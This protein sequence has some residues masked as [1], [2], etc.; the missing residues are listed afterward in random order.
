MRE[1]KTA[2]ITDVVERLCIEAN[3]QLPEDIKGAIRRCRACED[4]ETAQGVLDK[5]I[6]NFEIAGEEHVPICQ[7]T[8][9]ACVFAEEAFI[10]A[11]CTTAVIHPC[12]PQ[13]FFEQPNEEARNDHFGGVAALQDIVIAYVSG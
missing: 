2:E 4:W 12:H 9:M 13:L 5:I 7:D 11:D 6:E 8:G 3:E 1:I 10:R